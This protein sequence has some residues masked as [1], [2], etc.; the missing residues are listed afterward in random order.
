MKCIPR[1]SLEV[2]R[3]PKRELEVSLSKCGSR[4][5]CQ[6]LRSATA[7]FKLKDIAIQLEQ[8]KGAHLAW[9]SR[10]RAFVDGVSN[11]SAEE[12]VSDHDCSLGKWY[13]SEGKAKFSNIPQMAEL[14][15]P[16]KEMHELIKQA[17]EFKHS[18]QAQRGEQVFAKVDALSQELIRLIDQV[19]RAI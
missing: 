7:H 14:E 15:R 3:T 13:F 12:A 6:G 10:L 9:R 19:K 8:A 16:H 5:T 11:L 2:E 18:G 4:R 1:I 17:I